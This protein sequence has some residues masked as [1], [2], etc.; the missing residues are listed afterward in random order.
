[1]WR[2]FSKVQ[3]QGRCV[4]AIVEV[5]EWLRGRCVSIIGHGQIVGSPEVITRLSPKTTGPRRNR[6]NHNAKSSFPRT[7]WE[8]RPGRSASP[9]RAE[10]PRTIRG[11]A[12]GITTV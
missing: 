5:N 1:W 3:K 7:A 12:H 10:A 2:A 6:W 9:A 4:Q 11:D 8:C